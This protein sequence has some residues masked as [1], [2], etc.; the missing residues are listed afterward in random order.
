M[1]AWGA[2]QFPLSRVL[3]QAIDQ[4]SHQWKYSCSTV[5]HTAREAKMTKVRNQSLLWP[6]LENQSN[7]KQCKTK[8]PTLGGM[9]VHQF[10]EACKQLNGPL[11]EWYKTCNETTGSKVSLPKVHCF[12][13]LSSLLDCVSRLLHCVLLWLI[14]K[15]WLLSY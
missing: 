3:Q 10:S 5:L 13:S 12:L 15:G 7:I 1:L 9:Q 14:S 4:T 11:F 8:W 2:I 6:P